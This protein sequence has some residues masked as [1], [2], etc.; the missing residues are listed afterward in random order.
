M[1]NFSFI[2]ALETQLDMDVPEGRIPCYKEK[3]SSLANFMKKIKQ[4]FSVYYN[5]KH[6]RKG[7]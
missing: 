3:L 6:R 7:T 2:E 5:R 1:G 4:N